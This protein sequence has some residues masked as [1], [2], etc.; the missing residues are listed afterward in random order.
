MRLILLTRALY[1]EVVASVNTLSGS[2]V[3]RVSVGAERVEARSER[4]SMAFP[5]PQVLGL[6]LIGINQM[7]LKVVVEQLWCVHH[8]NSLIS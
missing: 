7:K 5:I 6:E 4:R 8:I 2:A 3:G 1:T